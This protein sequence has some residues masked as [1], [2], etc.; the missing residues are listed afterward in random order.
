MVI[1]LAIAGCD[2]QEQVL[3]QNHSPNELVHFGMGENWLATYSVFKVN[4]SLFDSIYIQFIGE[5]KDTKVG[6][7]EYELEGAEHRASSSYPQELQ[8]VGSFQVS[9]K[10]NADLFS[11]EPNADGIYKLTI[12]S[13]VD[14]EVLT[15][16]EISNS[17]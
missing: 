2:K 9:S 10:F 5:W 1:L 7:I 4:D 15:L 6:P 17:K 11:L 13:N 12:K 14:T 8:G 3:P 16:I